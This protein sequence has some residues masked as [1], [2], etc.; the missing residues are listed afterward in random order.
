[1]KKIK[2]TWS[3]LLIVVL[4]MTMVVP[5]YAV[6]AS[7]EET[8]EETIEETTQ[9]LIEESEKEMMEETEAGSKDETMSGEAE[10]IIDEINEQMTTLMPSFNASSV[11]EMTDNICSKI[12]ATYSSQ[13][14]FLFNVQM[15][16]TICVNMLR[17]SNGYT[18]LNCLALSPGLSEAAVRRA[19]E[20][21]TKFS[22]TRPNG[23]YFN[24]VL[25]EFSLPLAASAT[26]ENIELGYDGVEPVVDAWMNNSTSASK[27]LSPYYQMIGVGYD[28]SSDGTNAWTQILAGNL[29]VKDIDIFMESSYPTGTDLVD[30]IGFAFVTFT[31]G[32]YGY[33]PLL[34]SMV[35]YY[36]PNTSGTKE[37]TI[38]CNGYVY[39]KNVYFYDPVESFVERLYTELLG[40]SADP[41]GLK[42]WTNVLKSGKEQGAKVAQ[43]FIESPEFRNRNLSN[44]DYV[45]VLY[46]TF[47]DR[48]PDTQ[49]LTAWIDVLNRGLSRLHVFRGFA[50]SLEFSELCDNYG[51]IRGNANLTAPCDQNEGV[52]MFVVRNYRL[53]LYREADEAGLNAWCNA[54]LTGQN[55][56]KEVAHGFVFSDEFIKKKVSD[57]EYVEILY[58]VFMDRQADGAGLNAW[59]KVLKNGQSREH[60]F[61]GFADSVEFREICASYGIQ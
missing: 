18:T 20:I 25:S 22:S 6:E 60:V 42:E 51:I 28:L 7:D 23:T 12:P 15:Y 1:M 41:K 57:K 47:F 48:E 38:T 52:T 29:S 59:L 34:D 2:R 56:A 55:T 17:D 31:N 44:L 45:I 30:E 35:R 50:E 43:G 33:I 53:C 13:E 46:R 14:D 10:E 58:W 26:A 3:L 9:E 24:T 54:I 16:M 19:Q 49:G 8:I 5:A 37:I 40:R 36:D 61:N 32:M 39:S 11:M 21:Q 4:V 27:I